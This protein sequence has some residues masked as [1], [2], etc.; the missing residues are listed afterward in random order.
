M[1]A[2]SLIALLAICSVGV[3]SFSTVLCARSAFGAS[4]TPENFETRRP[5]RSKLRKHDRL[6]LVE[7][8]AQ[9][10]NELTLLIASVEGANQSVLRQVASLGGSVQYRDD[11]VSYLRVQV[12]TENVEKLARSADIQALNINGMMDYLNSPSPEPSPG[13]GAIANRVAPPGRNTPAE[14]PYLPGRDIGSPQFIAQHPTF[15]GRGVT[16]GIVDASIDL[17]SP[18]LQTAKTLDGR[19]TRKLADVLT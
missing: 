3:S 2:Q 8:E 17:L 1:G 19:P 5:S 6:R 7:A 12:P 15:D 13:D 10:E 4:A 16:I 11:D 18:E 9:G 14:N